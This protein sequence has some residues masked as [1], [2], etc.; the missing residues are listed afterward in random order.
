MI[1]DPVGPSH[2]LKRVISK[3]ST[4]DSEFFNS[5][6]RFRNIDPESQ[7]VSL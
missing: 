2:E 5:I 3:L 1:R 7:N 4:V 6:I